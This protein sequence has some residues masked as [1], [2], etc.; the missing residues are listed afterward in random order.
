MTKDKSILII[1]DERD[2]RLICSSFLANDFSTIF[3]AQSADEAFNILKKNTIDVAIVDINMPGTNGFDFIEIAKRKYPNTRFLIITGNQSIAN[4]LKAIKIGVFDFIEKP[5]SQATLLEK[6]NCACKNREHLYAGHSLK[7]VISEINKE[8]TTQQKALLLDLRDDIQ[9]AINKSR[10]N[11]DLL[12]FDVEQLFDSR[13]HGQAVSHLHCLTPT[14]QKISEML[15]A[16]FTAKA[17]S[18]KMNRSI[19]TI[20]VHIKSMRKKLGLV[21][22]APPEEKNA[23]NL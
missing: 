1:D 2:I 8:N 4:L 13:I 23:S 17:I 11:I 14:E 6:V 16:G 18:G 9:R 20:Q 22:S 15:V 12:K 10:G 5:F 3:D 21:K 19:N 7:S